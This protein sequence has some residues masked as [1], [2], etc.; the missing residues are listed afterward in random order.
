MSHVEISLKNY[1][2]ILEHTECQVK[3]LVRSKVQSENGQG[4]IGE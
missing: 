3:N 2:W 4:V 1:A